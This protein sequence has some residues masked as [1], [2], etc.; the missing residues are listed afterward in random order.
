[1]EVRKS[2]VKR[3]DRASRKSW[4]RFGGKMS[5]VADIVRGTLCVRAGI[6]ELYECLALLQDLECF[7]RA[8]CHIA[9]IHDGAANPRSPRGWTTI[10]GRRK[11]VFKAPFE[12]EAV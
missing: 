8:G 11:E 7:R 1:M 2:V 6:E 12:R 10:T 3:H 9:H 4:S 5:C